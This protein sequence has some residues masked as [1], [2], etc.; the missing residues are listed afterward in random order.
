[1]QM[2][3][4]RDRAPLPFH[5]GLAAPTENG[6][7]KPSYRWQTARCFHKC[8]EQRNSVCNCI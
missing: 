5:I 8:H 4:T 6:A 7:R 3:Q 2:E 1:M